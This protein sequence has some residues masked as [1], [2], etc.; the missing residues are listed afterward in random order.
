MSKTPSTNA[1]TILTPEGKVEVLYDPSEKQVVFHQS[2]EANVLFVGSRGTGKSVALR[3][4]AHIRAMSHPGLNYVILRR[5][6]PELQKSHLLFI[7]KEIRQLGGYYNKGEKIAYY[8]NGSRG[9]FSHC[10]AAED[11]LNLLSA[12]FQWMGFDEVSTFEWDMFTKLAASVR[13]KKDSG[14]IGMVRACTNP[15][16]VSADMINRYWVTKEVEPE[17]DQDYNKEDWKAI[18]VKMED[19]PFID[20]TQYIKRFAGLAAHVK[21]AWLDGE[22][23][24]ENALF[25][26]HPKK[27][28]KPYHVTSQVSIE[29]LVQKA[30]IYCAYDHGYFP[31]PAICLWIAHLGNRYIVFHEKLWYKTI[32]SDIAQSIKEENKRLGIPRVIVTYCDPTIDI[33]TGADIRTIKDIFESLGVPM[34][35]SINNREL[36]ASFV[37]TALAEESE[38][39]VPRLQLYDHGKFA[40]CPYLIKTLPQQRYDIKKPMALA[41][42]PQ[43]HGV[44]SLAYFL[45]SS[46]SMDRHK[47]PGLTPSKRWMMPKKGERWII[48]KDNVRDHA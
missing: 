12:E 1:I 35:C 7:D 40:G 19:A 31:D 29:D 46:G 15:L 13:V 18:K 33:H 36:Y 43:D 28:G 34:E 10:Q 16:G 8:P 37:H 4:D 44:V 22:F 38:P 14:L 17:E 9:F 23:A 5:T 25:D 48:G 24:L 20:Q 2:Q 11:V 41:N 47:A 26:F 42:H 45:I 27:N 3:W 21:T 39:G 32:V 30:Q 6:F